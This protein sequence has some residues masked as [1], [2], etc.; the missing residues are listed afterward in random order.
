MDLTRPLRLNKLPEPLLSHL[1][2]RDAAVWVLEPFVAEAGGEAVAEVV[3]LPWR[4]VLTESSDPALVASLEGPENAGDPLVRRRGFLQLVDTNPADVLL[5]PRCLPIYLLNG[6]SVSESPSGLAGLTRRLTMLEALRRLDVKELVILAGSG[7]ALPTELAGLWEDGLRTIVTVVS[8]APGAAAE[9]EVWRSA[10]PSGT[11]AAFL[12]VAAAA[13]CRDLVESYVSGQAD[14]R[15]ILRIRNVRGE[16]RHFDITGLDDPEYP[17]LANYQLLQNSHLRHL[18]PDDLNVNDVQGFFRDAASSWRPYAAGMPWPRDSEAWQNLRARL[19]RLDREGP[20]ATRIAYVSSES[21]AGGTTLVHMLAWTAAEE[22]YPT[23]IARA[24]PFTPKALEVAS[25]MTR[26]V[27]A[28]RATLPELE[29]ERLY[30]SPWLMVFDRMNWE[31]REGELR[32]FLRELE[33]SGR[34]ACVLVVT[35]PYL[36]VEYYDRKH[37]VRISEL[38]HEVSL[39]ET[40]ALGKHLNQYLAPHGPIRSESDWR[41]FYEASAI[42]AERGIAAFWIALSFWLQRQF[43]MNETIQAW[44]YKQYRDNISDPEVRRAILDVA[45]L[46]TERHPLPDSMLPPSTDWPLSQRIEDIRRDVPGLGLVRVTRDGDRYWAL[47]HDVIGRFLLTALFYDRSGR[48][49]AGLSDALNPE[50]LRFLILRRL[51]HLP[52][53]G[54]AINRAIAEEFAI[55]IFKIDPDHGHANLVPFWRDAL[56]ALDEM[57]KALR[58]SSRSFLHHSSISRRRISKQKELFP[59][60]SSERVGLLERAVEDINY[61]L[62]NIPATPGGETDLNLYNSLAL[63]YQDLADEEQERGATPDHVARL[64][65]RA[66]EATQRAYRTDPDNS[67]VVETY[68]RSLISDARSIPECT[69]VNAVEVINIVYAA[70]ER[71][72]SG[73]RR[74]ALSRLADTALGLLLQLELPELPGEEPTSEVDALVLAIRALAGG[75]RRFEG[76]ELSGFSSANRVRAAEL[77]AHSLLQGNPQ[78]VR[79]RYA[80][81]SLDAP[82]D[83][84]GQLELLHSLQDGGTVFSPQMRLELALLL[85]QCDRHHEAVRMFREL[86]RLWKESDHYVQVPERLRWLMTLDGQAPRQVTAKVVGSYELRRAAK[87]RELQDAEVLFRPQEFGQQEFRPGIVIRGYISFGH[88]GPFLRPTTAIQQ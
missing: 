56:S 30:E 49:A 5:P 19:R 23:L 17:V 88:N 34:P 66:H 83:F 67:F 44:I 79:L 47:A 72:K 54:L 40:V 69:A 82:F 55:S 61:A 51:S 80:L 1:D 27:E 74:F 16:V 10:R 78:A 32:Q 8:D 77:L 58:T 52:A 11:T 63:A 20:D 76:M 37:F 14:D 24:A 22:G 45:A 29:G 50:H 43:D 84:R 62:E 7:V 46:S 26:V 57:P 81:R 36:G 87:V 25:F 2:S 31:G 41:G 21:G 3:R 39:D 85:H 33:R 71:D 9:L 60:E 13:F 68:A 35:G 28:Q 15:F 75:A 38:S 48:D 86:R 65:A 18:Q 6:R 42:Q 4:V 53:L 12:P 64:R 73:Q 70:M 59:T